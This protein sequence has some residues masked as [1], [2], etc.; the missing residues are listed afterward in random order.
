MESNI[1]TAIFLPFALFIIM[2]GMGLGLTLQ[3]FRRL[4]IDPK[5]VM[6]GLGAQLLLLPLVGLILAKMFNLPPQLAVGVMVIA[7][8]PGGPTSNII[9]Y[10][11]KGN[12]ALSVTLTALSSLITVFTIPILINFSTQF[13]LDENRSLQLPFLKTVLQIAII[14]LIP[15][16]IGMTLHHFRPNFAAVIEKYVKWL[17]LFFLAV[18]IAGLLIKEKAN[19]PSFFVQAGTV[20]LCLNLL[21]MGLGYGVARL[22]KLDNAS[23]KSITIEVGLQNGTLAIAIASAPTF[24][25]S[26]T[27]AIPA[28]IYS[29]IMFAT[30]A[31]FGW[32]MGRLKT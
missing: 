30:G 27:M 19:L 14:T 1:L 11:I 16:A 20:T 29:L 23:V 5:G 22:S 17:S 6:V 32:L 15:V 9:T 31:S 8:C 21:T 26:P 7:V 24:L 12:V 4:V 2:F 28:A 10:L 18:I 13:F 25:N 3:D